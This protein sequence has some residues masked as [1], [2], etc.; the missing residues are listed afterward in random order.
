MNGTAD[1]SVT[2]RAIAAAGSGELFEFDPRDELSTTTGRESDTVG[3][4]ARGE[5]S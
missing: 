2:E 1:D 3:S 5:D 4:S